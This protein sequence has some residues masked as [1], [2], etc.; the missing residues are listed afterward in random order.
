MKKGNL[1]VRQG[2]LDPVV[3]VA[4]IVFLLPGFLVGVIGLCDS[5][6]MLWMDKRLAKLGYGCIGEVDLVKGEELVLCTV[7]IWTLQVVCG[8]P[9]QL[10]LDTC[11][12][13]EAASVLAPRFRSPRCDMSMVGRAA[14]TVQRAT[15]KVKWIAGERACSEQVTCEAGWH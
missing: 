7:S 3:V 1:L 11:G 5:V 2:A 8:W 10:T 9:G 4:E 6:T 13:L 15:R 14:V 12:T